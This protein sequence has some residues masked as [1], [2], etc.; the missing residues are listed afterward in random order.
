MANSD[1]VLRGVVHHRDREFPVL[2]PNEKGY[3]AARAAGAR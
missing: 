3:D 1:A 2:V